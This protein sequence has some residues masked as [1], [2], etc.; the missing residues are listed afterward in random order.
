MTR[1]PEILEGKSPSRCF[2]NSWLQGI[3][4]QYPV[5]DLGGGSHWSYHRFLGT[6]LSRTVA[7]NLP[8]ADNVDVIADAG[9]SLPFRDQSFKSVLCFNLLEHV[10]D[11]QNTIQEAHRVLKPDCSLFI[12]V[13]FLKRIHGHP[14]DFTRFTEARLRRDLA[15]FSSISVNSLSPG[16]TSA[17]ISILF[18]I[19][20]FS[21]IKYIMWSMARKADQFIH[22]IND[23]LKGSDPIYYVI[24]AVK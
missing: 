14:N 17:A 12:G 1:F 19:F 11:F 20:K 7:L 5:L 23:V 18:P 3:S 10:Y 22:N 4:L 16:P 9:S 2:L 24:E 6:D 13:P 15:D 21:I 8:S